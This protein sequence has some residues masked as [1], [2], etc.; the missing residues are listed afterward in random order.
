MRRGPVEPSPDP[1]PKGREQQP[2]LCQLLRLASTRLARLD[3]LNRLL[4]RANALI[5]AFVAT[6]AKTEALRG[7]HL[8]LLGQAV[9]GSRRDFPAQWL[10]LLSNYDN[11]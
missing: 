3:L 10:Q 6:A 9:M 1:S 2:P 4:D 5:A 7:R 11:F 8:H